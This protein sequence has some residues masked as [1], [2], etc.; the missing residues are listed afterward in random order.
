MCVLSLASTAASYSH[1]REDWRGAVN[2]LIDNTRAQ[3]A[4]VYY[5]SVGGWAAENYRDWLPGGSANRPT[6]VEV[7]PQSNDWQAKI[8]GAP[9]VWLVEYPENL[10]DD[11]ARAV[12]AEL[13][14]QYTVVASNGFRA[15]TVT[16]FVPKR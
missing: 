15:I 8:A 11:T 2:F 12:E 14:S 4:V 16:E 3:D 5:Q 10:S 6:A 1:V 13:H 7:S 9:R